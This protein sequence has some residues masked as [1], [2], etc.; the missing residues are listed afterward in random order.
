V[1][2]GYVGGW[3][4]V[5][6]R[7]CVGGV[8]SVGVWECGGMWVADASHSPHGNCWPL[9]VCAHALSL[10]LSGSPGHCHIIIIIKI[11]ITCY[12]IIFNILS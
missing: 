10:S 1:R 5:G 3:G 2:Y 11:I 7:G 4:G 9:R 12:G 6:V 8:G